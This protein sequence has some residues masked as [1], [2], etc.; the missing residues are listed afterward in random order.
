MFVSRYWRVPVMSP[1]FIS[2]FIPAQRP[3]WL[4]YPSAATTQPASMLNSSSS[5]FTRTP[6]TRPLSRRSP[7]AVVFTQIS[8]PAFA[9]SLAHALS[10]AS[11]SRTIPTSF[12]A[13][14]SSILR[15]FPDG[16]MIFAPLTSWATHLF[17]NGIAQSSRKWRATPSPQRTGEPISW[18]FSIIRVLQ[19]P[20]AAYRA[21]E[22]PAGPAP[23]TT[24]SYFSATSALPSPTAL[25]V[26]SVPL[27]LRLAFPGR[28][29][30]GLLQLG[31]PMAVGVVDRSDGTHLHAHP[32]LRA[33]LVEREV[34]LVQEDRVRRARPD[35]RPAVHA[36]HVVDRHDAVVP[37]VG[38]KGDELSWHAASATPQSGPR[39]S[40]RSPLG[41]SGP[42]CRRRTGS[43]FR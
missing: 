3:T 27:G 12:P 18:R 42:C 37:D 5:R 9:A 43:P 1:A 31:Q 15:T 33:V 26:F 7:T 11:R 2:V 41:S 35:A 13:C 20:I 8:A 6:V 24:T 28:G 14:F 38:T 19:P 23:T 34:H 17:S 36:Q 10:N 22:L 40:S 30:Q 32:A 16:E 25:K 4:S 21:A 39:T 29:E